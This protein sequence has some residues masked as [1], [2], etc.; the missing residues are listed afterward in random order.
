MVLMTLSP[1]KDTLFAVYTKLRFAS[2]KSKFWREWFHV[3]N[4]LFAMFGV[5][6]YREHAAKVW[7]K[8]R[9]QWPTAN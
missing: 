3:V 9:G 5:I 6:L 1:L 8:S 2:Q 4:R 7:Q